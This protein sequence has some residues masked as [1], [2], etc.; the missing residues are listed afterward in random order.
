MLLLVCATGIAISL[1][2]HVG[3]LAGV[4]W[5]GQ[6]RTFWWC[7]GMLL[8]AYLPICIEII[9]T[10]DYRQILQL[11]V[12]EQRV[13]WGIAAY[14]AGSFYW[15]LYRA[16]N[17]LEGSYTWEMISAGMLLAF[18]IAAAHYYGRYSRTKASINEKQ[19]GPTLPSP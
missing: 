2:F 9:H 11:S 8:V 7:Q 15:F 4:D 17:H 5:T 3:A 1:V 18:G 6:S 19:S 12:W 14:Y 13:L 10:K 16:A